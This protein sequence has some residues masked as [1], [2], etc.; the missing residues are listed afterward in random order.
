MFNQ[1]FGEFINREYLYSKNI[2][3]D[4][5]KD[6]ISKH[7]EVIVKPLSEGQGRG[8]FKIKEYDLDEQ[9]DYLI[10]NNYLIEEVIIPQ[11]NYR[12]SHMYCNTTY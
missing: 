12:K 9:I 1:T 7:K 4:S 5:L 2:T 10:A 3:K 11:K 8:I 6:F